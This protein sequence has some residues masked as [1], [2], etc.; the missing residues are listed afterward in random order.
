MLQSPKN[1]RSS[2]HAHG[3]LRSPR[4]PHIR[5]PNKEAQ[6]KRTKRYR[7]RMRREKPQLF[8]ARNRA[9]AARYSK[10]EK[11]IRSRLARE[12]RARKLP[13]QIKD[14]DSVVTLQSLKRPRLMWLDQH[15]ALRIEEELSAEE[16]IRRYEA[17]RKIREKEGHPCP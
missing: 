13:N 11:G 6:R 15:G 1:Q 8:A 2:E 17:T 9:N 16:L 12:E 7:D 5:R 3:G 14:T 10:T 4:R